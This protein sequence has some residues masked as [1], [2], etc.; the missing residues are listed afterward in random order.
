MARA[1]ILAAGGIV[2]RGSHRPL[3]AIVQLRKS[4]NW[5]LPKGKLKPTEDAIAAAKREVLEETG[6]DVLVHE[7]LGSMTYE[8]GGG[9][10]KIVQF[11]RMQANGGPVRELMCDVKAVQWLPLEAALEKL[12]HAREQLFLANVGPIVLKTRTRP[13]RLNKSPAQPAR[14]SVVNS[15]E[16]SARKKLGEIHRRRP[17]ELVAP[18]T[19]T[20]EDLV[21]PPES[22]V[23]AAR[24]SLV[25][26]VWV[27][28]RQKVLGSTDT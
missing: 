25:E 24:K 3:I 9:R 20:R 17:K 19:R 11:W 13:V 1:P 14:K 28:V 15:T 2:V 26:K 27:W 4:K 5:V 22:A 23:P 8:V 12:S 6:H 21:A 10:A 18:E 16:R 7:F